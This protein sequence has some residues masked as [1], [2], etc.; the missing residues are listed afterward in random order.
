MS[1]IATSSGKIEVY[2]AELKEQAKELNASNEEE[3][4]KLSDEFPLILN[5][6]RHMKY[7]ANTL[8]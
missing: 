6:G 8:M 2:I 5:A 4:L 1:G 3:G 7:N